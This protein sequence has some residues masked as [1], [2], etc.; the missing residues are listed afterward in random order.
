MPCCGVNLYIVVIT[1]AHFDHI[2][3]LDLY[4]GSEIIIARA[5]LD[6]A[7]G[8]RPETIQKALREGHVTTVEDELLIE[9]TL[10]F[11][12]IGGHE[13]GSSVLYFSEGG[14]DYV[15]TGDECYACDNVLSN[16]PI[17]S[18]F[19][20]A[21]KNAAFTLDA[22]RRGLIPLPCH[23]RAVFEAYSKVSPNVARVV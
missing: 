21:D 1:H 19:M 2:D 5:A 6:A 16:R 9:G 23:D 11:K 8:E 20:D 22:H 17:G 14:K 15:L 13:A 12:V 18:I 4:A 7:L 10:H 3:N